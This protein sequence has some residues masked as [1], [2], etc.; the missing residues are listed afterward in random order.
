MHIQELTA[1]GGSGWRPI[2]D[3]DGYGRQ[4]HCH[5]CRTIHAIEILASE[6]DRAKP[7]QRGIADLIVSKMHAACAAAMP[8]YAGVDVP[9]D[10]LLKSATFKDKLAHLAA[11]LAATQEGRIVDGARLEQ[12]V[13]LLNRELE[14]VVYKI[15]RTDG[16]VKLTTGPAPDL[17]R[18]I[19]AI[20]EG[21][22]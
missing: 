9:V 12:F 11:L 14:N 22:K 8:E 10:R 17:D 1:K 3:V 7:T 18:L 4:Y 2:T 6:I 16:G 21:L 20:R 19:S 5:D 13:T 15:D